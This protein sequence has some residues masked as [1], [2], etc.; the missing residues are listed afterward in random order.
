VAKNDFWLHI[1]VGALNL[2]RLLTLGLSRH[3][4]TWTLAV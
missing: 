4:D 3:I 2:R 1:R